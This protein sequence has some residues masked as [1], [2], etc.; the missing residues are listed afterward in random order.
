[1]KNRETILL[2]LV[3]LIG[4][5]GLAVLQ[6]SR[7]SSAGSDERSLVQ[8]GA[9]KPNLDAANTQAIQRIPGNLISV[10]EQPEAGRPFLFRMANFAQG[11]VYELDLGDGHRKPFVDGVLQHTYQRPGPHRV[12]LYARYEGQE[13]AIDSLIKRV[14][15]TVKQEEVAPIVDY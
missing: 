13:V 2:A 5:G 10:N 12:T 7:R 1:M 15:Q 4:L 11:A 9:E 6:F 8:A 3:A 14:A